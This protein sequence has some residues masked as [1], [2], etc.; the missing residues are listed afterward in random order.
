MAQLGARQGAAGQAAAGMMQLGNLEQLTEQAALD[1]QMQE[2][3]RQENLPLQ[4]LGALVAAAGGIPGN[5]GTQ[6]QSSSPGFTGVLGA[7]GS[8]GQGIGAMRGN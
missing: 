3:M 5:L 4:Q 2:F 1:A 8:L 6:N 7:I